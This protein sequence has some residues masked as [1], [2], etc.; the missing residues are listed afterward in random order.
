MNPFFFGDSKAPLFGVYLAPRVAVARDSAVVICPATA[1][2]YAR[3]VDAMH[4]LAQAIADAGH[5]V[6]CFDYHATGS[7]AGEI[8]PGQLL[9]WLRNVDTAIR[10]A[11][12]L[13]GATR[14]SV[15]GIRLGGLLAATAVSTINAPI[16]RLVLLDAVVSGKEYVRWIRNLRP[17]YFW[18]LTRY[19]VS[20]WQL[21]PFG[22]PPDLVSSLCYLDLRSEWQQFALVRSRFVCAG[23]SADQAL[24][25]EHL[26][27]KLVRKAA[28][29]AAGDFSWES[30]LAAN[31]QLPANCVIGPVLAAL[32]EGS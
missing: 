17:K 21:S 24:L 8:G 26:G 5:H 4:A 7:S 14:L 2:D 23:R 15:L 13:S 28:A 16:H 22:Y 1:P 6:L 19:R 31:M 18:P 10:E 25:E 32:E 3:S 29:S 12:A 30:R 20:A 9:R 11:A 27:R